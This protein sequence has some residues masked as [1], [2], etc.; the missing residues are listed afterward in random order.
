MKS[1]AFFN[2]ALRITLT[3]AGPIFSRWPRQLQGF[4]P[5]CLWEDGSGDVSGGSPNA[6]FDTSPHQVDEG[7]TGKRRTNDL[8]Q[9]PV[10]TLSSTEPGK[11]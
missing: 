4:S 9:R 5:Q 1:P 2:P 6:N 3:K 7:M 10:W 11:L 8:V